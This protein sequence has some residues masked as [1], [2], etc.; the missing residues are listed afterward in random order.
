MMSSVNGFL[1][2]LYPLLKAQPWNGQ[3]SG[4]QGRAEACLKLVNSGNPQLVLTISPTPNPE[5][6]SGALSSQ[7]PI[8]HKT[9]SF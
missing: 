8:S 3:G 5:T 6:G 2:T 7:D 9:P 1:P 4:A